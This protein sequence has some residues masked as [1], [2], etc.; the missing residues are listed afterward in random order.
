MLS[1]VSQMEKGKN[2]MVSFLY[3][4][5]QKAANKTNKTDNRM[6]ITSGKVSGGGQR[7]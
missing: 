1:E 3:G 5:K 2:H 6:V 7:M 4:I